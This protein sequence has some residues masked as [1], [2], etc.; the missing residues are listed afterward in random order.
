MTLVKCKECHN[1]V[2][3]SAKTCPKC[4]AKLKKGRLFK[5]VGILFSMFIGLV[6]IG[7]LMSEGDSSPAK[8]ASGKIQ[9]VSPSTT[10]QT[11]Q[12]KET[13]FGIGDKV[14]FKDSE[15]IVLN[16]KQLGRVLNG[17]DFMESKRTEG[18][19]LRVQYKV[20][21]LT[22]EEQSIFF[23]PSIEDS[24]GR[25]FEQFDEQLMYLPDGAKSIQME[26]L[27]AGISK[28]FYA[29]YELPGDA[30]GIKFQTRNFSAW[31]TEYKLVDLAT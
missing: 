13:V 21:N 28:K 23:A 1:E 26:A 27:P 3:K 22:N 10:Q 20:K 6:V 16:V 25:K 11:T 7:A 9:S 29:I 14:T 24:K 31:S 18:K 30:N 17:G 12:Q 4:G 5:F 8:K 2:S 15:W 19:F